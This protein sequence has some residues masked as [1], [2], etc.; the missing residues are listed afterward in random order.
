MNIFK[1]LKD[2]IYEIFYYIF[3]YKDYNDFII[4]LI[5]KISEHN[6]IF[7]KIFQ[8]TWA[9]NNN[10]TYITPQIENEIFLFTNNTPYN[11]SDIDY[12]SLLDLYKIASLNNDIFE[13]ES[14]V[15][16][17]SG[18]ISLVFK[19]KLNKQD[20]IVKILRKNI[21]DQIKKGIDL[22][23]NLENILY[24]IPII[25][26]YFTTKIFTNNKEHIFNQ[27]NFINETENIVMFKNKLKK[28]KFISI[29]NVYNQYTK[30]NHNLILM[31]YI[32]GKYLYELDMNDLDNFFTPFYKFIVNTIF[33][34]K[35]FHCDLHQ[36][37]ILFIK[38]NTL[39]VHTYKI[40]IIDFGMI[41]QLNTNEIDF[42]FIWLNG[43]FNYKFYEMIEYMSNEQNISSIFE[44]HE[45]IKDCIKVLVNLYDEKKIFCKFET[46]ENLIGDVHLFLNLFKKFNCKI[47]H[48]YNF[49]ILSLIPVFSVLIKLGPNINKK[50]ILKEILDKIQPSDLLD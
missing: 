23:I 39:N 42:I 50:N 17:N 16:I 46:Y 18:S 47:S 36:G 32:S 1:L 20:I 28:N 29:P 9:S 31:D 35:I 45:Q 4:S 44:N 30:L 12:K 10:N 26:Y 41:T 27:I 25:N 15:P 33:Y 48:R 40:G 6:I 21:N 37:N 22:L 14:T 38:E 43:I 7:I 19:A 34:K 2:I 8:W 11:E 24:H 3:K 5:R 49:F 13:L